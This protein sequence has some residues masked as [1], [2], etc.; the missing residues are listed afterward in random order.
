M[1]EKKMLFQ[2]GKIIVEKKNNKNKKKL[3]I[4]S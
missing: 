3:E 4:R 2:I 1:N